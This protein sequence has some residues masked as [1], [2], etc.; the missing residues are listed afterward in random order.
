MLK[1]LNSTTMDRY[2]YI[3]SD[4]SDSYFKDN[5]RC[6]FK[7]HLKYP[8]MLPG[9]WKV[10][11]VAFYTTINTRQKLN[12]STLYLYCNFCKE[13]LVQGELRKLLRNIPMTKQNKWQHSFQNVYVPVSS[14]EI[15]EMEFYIKNQRWAAS[16]ILEQPSSYSIAL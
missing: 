5:E 9:T 14:E 7:I 3:E 10:G 1:Q 15:L 16:I 13:S 8:L 2:V 11:L 4:D 6:K 12:S